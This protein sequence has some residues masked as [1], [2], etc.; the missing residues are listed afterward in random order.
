MF[1]GR[2]LL[3][4]YI[5]SGLIG[6]I[7][8]LHF[9]QYQFI[10]QHWLAAYVTCISDSINSLFNT[11]W[12]HMLLAFPTV[13]I[14]CSTLI[15]CIC[16]MHFRQYQFIVQH[17]LAA[18]VTCI[19]NSINS[20]FNTDWL[21]MLHAFPTV[22]IHCSTLIGCICY[23]HFRQ[24]QFI[25]QHWL[26]AYVTCIS[27]MLH[28]VSIHCST[29]IGCIC[30]MHF[31]SINSLFNTDWLHMLHAFQQYQ[32]IVQISL[33][34]DLA[35]YVTCISDSINSLFN[36]DWLHM[37]HAFP[38]VSI[39]CSTLIGCICYMHSQFPVL[40]DLAQHPHVL[41]SMLQAAL[42]YCCTAVSSLSQSVP[43]Q[44]GLYS[45]YL[46]QI[47]TDQCSSVLSSTLQAVPVQQ[48][49][50]LSP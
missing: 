5:Y 29:L 40:S 30:Y 11:D 26:A 35:A 31:H 32:F 41:S 17:W 34:T 3:W 15:G 2:E 12:L 19:S 47:F 23:M 45:I 36:T 7:C 16:Y 21:H 48:L 22:S 42:G 6:C 25:V 39:H 50:V 27:N 33:I 8:Y 46:V 10:V 1:D 4:L 20:L 44:C 37:L 28:A 43:A 14:H 9:R 38:T 49:N 13:S 18:Y 24:Y